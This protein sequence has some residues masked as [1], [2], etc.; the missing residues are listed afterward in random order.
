MDEREPSE[1]LAYALR[2]ATAADVEVL[3]HIQRTALGDYVEEVFG[4]DA[5]AQR[6]Y[7]D[8]HFEWWKHDLVLVEGAVVG[9]FCFE[10]RE[11]H[12]YLANV[13]LLPSHQ[14]RGLGARLLARVVASADENGLPVRL[15]VLRSNPARN[16]YERHGFELRGRTESHLL[17][18]RPPSDG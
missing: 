7:F 10:R 13:A 2:R 18:A 12:V 3:W 1:D 14:R 8:E 4:T 11:D 5:A 17:M 16:F 15:Q 6:A 9:F